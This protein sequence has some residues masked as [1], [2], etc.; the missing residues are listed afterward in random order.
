[1]NEQN[2]SS[3]SDPQSEGIG[4]TASKAWQTTRDKAGEAL[5]A[6]ER[7]VRENP[8]MSAL[9]L[10]GIGFVMGL[11]V[12]WSIAHEDQESAAHRFARR[13]GNKVWD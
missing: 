1:M 9:S 10:F 8:T 13:W 3:T 6:G 11:L 2:F 4:E 7:Y 5:H 12:G